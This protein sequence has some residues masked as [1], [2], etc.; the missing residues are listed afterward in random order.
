VRRLRTEAIW[1]RP[2]PAPP[3]RVVQRWKRPRQGARLRL[4]DEMLGSSGCDCSSGVRSPSGAD[5]LAGAVAVAPRFR[6]AAGVRGLRHRRHL[7]TRPSTGRAECGAIEVGTPSRAGRS[8]LRRFFPIRAFA[9]ALTAST[10]ACGRTAASPEL[11]RVRRATGSPCCTPAPAPAALTAQSRSRCTARPQLRL[12]APR[13]RLPSAPA[14]LPGRPGDLRAISS[15]CAVSLPPQW[16]WYPPAPGVRSA[17]RPPGSGWGGLPPCA[18]SRRD[19]ER[20]GGSRCSPTSPLGRLRRRGGGALQELLEIRHMGGFAAWSRS[21]SSL[22]GFFAWSN[23]R[24]RTR[25]RWFP[26]RAATGRGCLGDGW[27]LRR[28]GAPVR[29]ARSW[30]AGVEWI[31]GPGS[32]DRFRRPPPRRARGP[33]AL[34]V[35]HAEPLL[36]VRHVIVRSRWARTSSST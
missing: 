21:C 28:A 11:A 8:E 33:G 35:R 17:P 29:N 2:A 27:R 7:E 1:P 32:P 16:A 3:T 26:Q 10:C 31:D 19:Q 13:R 18:G 12:G 6:G 36:L 20:P 15:D 4:A 23:V 30:P 5:A 22:A 34:A 24:H 9:L 14:S 25:S